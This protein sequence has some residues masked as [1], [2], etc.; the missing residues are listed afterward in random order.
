MLSAITLRVSS[1]VQIDQQGICS[2]EGAGSFPSISFLYEKGGISSS[3]SCLV[4]CEKSIELELTLTGVPVLN[5]KS[6]TPNE[7][8]DEDNPTD[9]GSPSGPLSTITSPL[10]ILASIYVPE[11]I[12]TARA[13][14]AKLPCQRAYP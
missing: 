14:S 3:P 7:L 9:L 11:Q 4:I 5:L 6:G 1:V 12:T 8:R 13:T 10:I 2:S